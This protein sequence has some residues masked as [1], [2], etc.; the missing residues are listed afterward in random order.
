MRIGIHTQYYAPEPGAPSAR[1]GSL[2][3]VARD[4]GHDVCVLTGM[5]SYPQGVVQPGYGGVWKRDE[6]DGIPVYRSFVYPSNSLQTI[7]RMSSYMAFAASSAVGGVA[8]LPKLDLLITESPPLTTGAAG[9]AIAKAKRAKWI[10]NV[11]DLWPKSAVELGV[12]QGERTIK[13]AEALERFSYRHAW[14]VSGQSESI[15]ADINQRFPEVRTVALLNGVDTARFGREKRSD[16]IRQGDFEGAEFVALY[17]GL[18]GLAQ[19]LSQLL[20][21]AERVA[22]LP[23]LRVVLVGDGPEKQA[24]IADAD[25]RGLSNVTFLSGRAPAE[26]PPLLASADVALVPLKGAIT[27]A[28]PS[29]VYEAFASSL[30]VVLAAEGEAA[31]IVQ[32]VDAGVVVKP[33]RADDLAAALRSLYEDRSRLATL[34]ANGRAAAEERFDRAIFAGRFLQTVEDAFTREVKR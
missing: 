1:L 5:P 15:L 14:M 2:A 4:R 31:D 9:Y 21:A 34:G 30:P 28:V 19:G 12:L 6:V 23:G 7:K 18:H 10:F 8:G 17:A 11:S 27:G 32:R 24:L 25:R 22:D 16:V 13:I 26:V 20:D 29:K 3:A 33:D